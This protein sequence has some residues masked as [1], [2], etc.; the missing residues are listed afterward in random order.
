MRT[1]LLTLA[2][3][4]TGAAVTLTG[5]AQATTADHA[6]ATVT[7]Q[8]GICDLDNHGDANNC[9]TNVPRWLI[10]PCKY[11]DSRN[12]Y[13]NAG[14]AGNGRGHSFYSIPVKGGGTCVVYWQNR[15]AKRHNYCE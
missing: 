3:F 5:V 13:W 11:E 4:L 6:Q 14:E 15:Y 10:T 8:V 12:C 2:A 9:R 7:R 1:F